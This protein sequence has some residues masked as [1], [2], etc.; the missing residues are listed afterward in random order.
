MDASFL[1]KA[2]YKFRSCCLRIL[3]SNELSSLSALREPCRPK[4]H[5]NRLTVVK[6][7][8]ILVTAM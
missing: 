5:T 8:L 1:I 2:S 6:R 7:M 3:G 4:D